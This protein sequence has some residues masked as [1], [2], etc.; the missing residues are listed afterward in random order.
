MQFFLY[1]S[2]Y[3]ALYVAT[4]SFLT[5]GSQPFHNAFLFGVLFQ[6]LAR[7]IAEW[8]ATEIHYTKHCN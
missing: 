2:I 6:I 7:P 4:L 8:L 5:D 3:I 1:G